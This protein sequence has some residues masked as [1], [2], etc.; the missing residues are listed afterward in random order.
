M[1]SAMTQKFCDRI[2]KTRSNNQ[3]RPFSF[4]SHLTVGCKDDDAYLTNRKVSGL[5][6]TNAR[7]WSLCEKS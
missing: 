4:L 1:N 3:K 2:P 7:F 6:N 5:T